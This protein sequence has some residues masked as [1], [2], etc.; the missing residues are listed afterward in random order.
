MNILHEG[1][2]ITYGCAVLLKACGLLHW[3]WHEVVLVPFLVAALWFA[4][5]G[6][7]EGLRVFIMR[8]LG[9]EA[10]IKIVFQRTQKRPVHTDGDSNL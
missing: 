3:P 5:Y 4:L 6:T 2:L 9:W 1:F 8:L 7:L 10:E